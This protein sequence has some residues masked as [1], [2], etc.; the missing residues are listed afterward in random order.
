MTKQ[1]KEQYRET[2]ELRYIIS[3]LKGMKFR[4]DCGHHVTFAHHLGNDITIRQ[5]SGRIVCSQCGY[6][7]Y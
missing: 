5:D 6:E 1:Q 3:Q 2:A 4:P 7:G